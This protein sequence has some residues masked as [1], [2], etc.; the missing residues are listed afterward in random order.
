MICTPDQESRAEY[1]MKRIVQYATNP[2]SQIRVVSCLNLFRHS[3]SG[4]FAIDVFGS[5]TF[6]L[7]QIYDKTLG[8]P[9]S[10]ECSIPAPGTTPSS[11]GIQKH[12][13]RLK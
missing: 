11:K 6:Y 2:R 13:E 10:N 5:I 9:D 1:T 8:S 4:Q 7:R 12:P 3:F